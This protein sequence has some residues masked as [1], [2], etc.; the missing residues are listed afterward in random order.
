MDERAIIWAN[1][2][3]KDAKNIFTYYN[4]RNHSDSYSRQLYKEM[5]SLM[6]KVAQLP[7]IG[8]M[9]DCNNV[10]YAIVK[11][12]LLFY[13]ISDKDIAVLRIWD[14]RQNPVYRPYKQY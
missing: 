5:T 13:H 4:K 8:K 12:Y 7:T 1:A 14:S 9:T 6:N 11:E 2:S 3:L 10:R